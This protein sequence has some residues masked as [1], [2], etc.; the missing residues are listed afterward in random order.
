MN[1]IIHVDTVDKYNKLFGLE[2]LHPL[3]SVVDLSK[4]TMCPKH[5][6]INYGVYAL[7]LKNLKCGDIRYGRQ[8]Y[9]YQEGTVVSFAPGQ[10][11][12]TEILE[13][14][15]LS[16]HGLLFHPDFIRGTSLGQDIKTYSFFSYDSNEALHLS[17]EERTILLDCLD[18]IERELTRDFHFTTNIGAPVMVRFIRAKDG[19]REYKGTLEAYDNGL[20]TVSC[21]DGTT[22][23][24]DKKETSW[25]KLDDFGGF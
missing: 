7:F 18:K 23:S 19:R 2:T 8:V 15:K 1:D 13:G 4:A 17:D 6:T 5:F 24:F 3:V 10:V 14:T 22:L 16:A 25:V 12:E 20:V 11:A 21:P 9:D